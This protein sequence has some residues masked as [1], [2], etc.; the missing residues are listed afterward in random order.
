M[1]GT[2]HIAVLAGD[3]IGPETMAGALGVLRAAAERFAFN[4]ELPEAHVGGV[5]IDRDGTALPAATIALCKQSDAILFGS[6]GGP[7]WES[8]PAAEQPERAALLPLRQHFGLFANLR[9]SR[10]LPE[11]I[12]ASPLRADIVAGGFDILCV[13]ELT[14]GLYFGKPRSTRE[15]NGDTI[16]I[17][18]MVYRR[19]EIDRVARV[20][21][22]AARPRRRKVTSV[23]KANVL[24]N[25]ILWRKT[26][27]TV[28]RDF[29]DVALEHLYVDNAAMQVIRRPRDFDVLLTENL[30]G[31]ILSDELAMLAGSLGMLPSASLGGVGKGARRFGLY[32]P[33]GGSAP[34]LAGRDSANPIAQILS[35]ALML[36]HTFEREDVASAIER[37]VETVI[38]SGL[39]TPDIHAS[40][41]RLVG[42][43]EMSDAIAEA[44][45]AG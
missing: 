43:R 13:R 27:T 28:A 45:G 8:L 39:R 40:D 23:D 30:F 32:E 29:P 44:L 7:K 24:D 35:V 26:V 17:D 38:A 14:G 36:R 22:Q 5:A 10:C 25:S 31:D 2:F 3:G 18:T 12:H 20:A 34:D 1:S 37:A 21:F 41:G 16:A 6:V 19:S 11:L 9:P 33:G 4:L 15:E 42:T